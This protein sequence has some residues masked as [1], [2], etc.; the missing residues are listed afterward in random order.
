MSSR[1]PPPL[2]VA[3]RSDRSLSSSGPGASPSPLRSPL[4]ATSS[5]NMLTPGT[6]TTTSGPSSRIF[7]SPTLSATTMTPSYL[8]PSPISPAASPS[9]I[10]TNQQR[11]LLLNSPSE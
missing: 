10:M 6:A 3:S 4:S 5:S 1:I 2:S 8:Q 7:S 9:T 11:S